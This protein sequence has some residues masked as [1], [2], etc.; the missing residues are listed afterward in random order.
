MGSRVLLL[1]GRSAVELAINAFGL[2][3]RGATG[4]RLQPIIRADCW[5]ES[6]NERG[7]HCGVICCPK[8]PCRV[9]KAT[10]GLAIVRRV[11]GM[12]IHVDTARELHT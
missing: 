8:C 2:T 3:R 10:S 6:A 11:Y 9:S 12:G 1:W 5:S 7:S 4:L